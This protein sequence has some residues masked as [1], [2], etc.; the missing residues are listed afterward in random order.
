MLIILQFP[1]TRRSDSSENGGTSKQSVTSVKKGREKPEKKRIRN[2]D[3]NGKKEKNLW[4]DD[5][6]DVLLDIFGE[7]TV[8]YSEVVVIK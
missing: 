1:R 6:M 7:E 5:D 2:T 3:T 4:T 8:L